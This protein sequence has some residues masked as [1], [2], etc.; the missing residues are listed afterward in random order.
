[1]ESTGP[2]FP[3][4]SQIEPTASSAPIHQESGDWFWKIT[5]KEVC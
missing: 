3:N 5:E 4:Q 1:M 2:E